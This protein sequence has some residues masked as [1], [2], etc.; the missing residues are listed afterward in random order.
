RPRPDQSRN[1]VHSARVKL[2]GTPGTTFIA[3]IA[4]DTAAPASA[5]PR[6]E[7]PR[8]RAAAHVESQPTPTASDPTSVT[9]TSRAS[10]RN[11]APAVNAAIRRIALAGVPTTGCTRASDG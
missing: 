4:K 8:A 3:M 9:G 11:D 2:P 7:I 6:P 1:A 5:A 10:P